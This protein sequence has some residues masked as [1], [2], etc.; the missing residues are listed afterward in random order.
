MTQFYLTFVELLK[1]TFYKKKPY[2]S[3]LL[4]E[5]SNMLCISRFETV[6][7]ITKHRATCRR[8]LILVDLLKVTFIQ[9]GFYI[10]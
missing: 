10:L 1:V 6:D 3:K 2:L 5:L 9:N 4:N 7:L 8:V